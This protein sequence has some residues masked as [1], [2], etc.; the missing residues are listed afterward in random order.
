M[1]NLKEISTILLF[2]E[3]KSRTEVQVFNSKLYNGYNVNIIPKFNED[4]TPI[5]IPL[6]N[7]VLVIEDCLFDKD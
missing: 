7:T 2:E 3:L 4:R 5:Q 1:I 6:N